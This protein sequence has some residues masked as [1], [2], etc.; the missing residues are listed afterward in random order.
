MGG[1]LGHDTVTDWQLGADWGRGGVLYAENYRLVP[2]DTWWAYNWNNPQVISFRTSGSGRLGLLGFEGCC[3]GG[4]SLRYST[5][6]R[7]T[8]NI[9]AVPEPGTLALLGMSLAAVG[10]GVRRKRA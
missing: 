3:G 1:H 8:W 2:G 4:M 7:Q 9:A 5:D 10:F 6:N